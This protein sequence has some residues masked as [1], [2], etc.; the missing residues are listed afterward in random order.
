MSGLGG[1]NKTPG[2]IVISVVQSQLFQVDTPADLAEAV[3]HVV[4]LVSRAKR[5]YLDSLQ[6]QIDTLK[7]QQDASSAELN[8]L[9]PSILDKAFKGEL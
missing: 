5:A 6:A 1:L 3:E 9:L 4:S 2:G 8:A 7:R